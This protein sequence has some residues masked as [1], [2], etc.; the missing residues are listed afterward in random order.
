MNIWI[1]FKGELESSCVLV[2]YF[3]KS[4]SSSSSE[5]MHCLLWFF[6]RVLCS[7]YLYFYLH[8]VWAVRFIFSSCD[9]RNGTSAKNNF[10]KGTSRT[11]IRQYVAVP[12]SCLY[13]ANIYYLYTLSKTLGDMLAERRGEI[14]GPGETLPLPLQ[15][16][17][18]SSQKVSLKLCR[19]CM[20]CWGEPLSCRQ[21][22]IHLRTHICAQSAVRHCERNR[23]FWFLSSWRNSVGNFVF[24]LW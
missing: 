24:P 9:R 16:A 22:G 4:I 18:V 10:K 2:T 5:L 3:P 20:D 1:L 11:V 6:L 13:H 7:G 21:A 23:S 19:R 14:E 17:R 15:S 8:F 12:L